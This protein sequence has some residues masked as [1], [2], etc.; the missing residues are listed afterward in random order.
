MTIRSRHAINPQHACHSADVLTGPER[1]TQ[2]AERT[3]EVKVRAMTWGDHPR[4][5][6]LLESLRTK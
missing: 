2:R 3:V 1:A 5:R 6:K 4:L